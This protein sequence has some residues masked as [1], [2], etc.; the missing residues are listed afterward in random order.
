LCETDDLNLRVRL[1][2][3]DFI[4]APFLVVTCQCQAKNSSP[5]QNTTKD[6]LS[7]NRGYGFTGGRFD[8]LEEILK[9]SGCKKNW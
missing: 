2:L 4:L 6:G 8:L 7:E 1:G 3:P 5:P 9:E